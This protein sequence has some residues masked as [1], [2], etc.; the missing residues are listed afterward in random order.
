MGLMLFVAGEAAVSKLG[1]GLKRVGRNRVPVFTMVLCE[2]SRLLVC[3]DMWC[4]V[5][6]RKMACDIKRLHEQGKL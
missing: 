3:L 5:G 2:T 1:L 4:Y 6:R